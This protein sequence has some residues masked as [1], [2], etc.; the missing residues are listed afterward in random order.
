MDH[1]V[2]RKPLQRVIRQSLRFPSKEESVA[3][4]VSCLAVAA[5]AYR[6]HNPRPRGPNGVKAGRKT[7]V[8]MD[9]GHVVIIQ[10]RAAYLGGVERKPERVHEMQL[11]ACIRGQPDDIARIRGNFRFVQDDVEHGFWP[12]PARL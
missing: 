2:W 6:F 12:R 1:L 3:R 5:L 11:A 7:V 9:P 4:Q 10:P 8:L